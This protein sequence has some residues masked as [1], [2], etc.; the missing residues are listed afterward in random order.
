MEEWECMVTHGPLG[1]VGD[2]HCRR[3]SKISEGGR[4]YSVRT[5]WLVGNSAISLAE[6]YV[7]VYC[8][9]DHGRGQCLLS[10]FFLNWSKVHWWFKDK[11]DSSYQWCQY[12]GN[13][14][15]PSK[16]NV[17]TQIPGKTLK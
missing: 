7:K 5:D 10:F 4:V 11:T 16:W 2:I 12:T 1:V 14:A 6:F 13:N 3:K 8:G 15:P 17:K 9:H